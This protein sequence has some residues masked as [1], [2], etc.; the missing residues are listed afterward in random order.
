MGILNKYCLQLSLDRINFAVDQIYNL[1]LDATKKSTMDGI[2]NQIQTILG[3]LT[4]S[5]I[6][7]II[8]LFINV[9]SISDERKVKMFN[10]TIT[11]FI[12]LLIIYML[13]FYTRYKRKE[14]YVIK[15][16][17]HS[18]IFDFNY[19]IIP[20]L[21]YINSININ[22]I[23]ND[24]PINKLIKNKIIQ[25]YSYIVKNIKKILDQ[26]ISELNIPIIS[27]NIDKITIFKL[28]IIIESIEYS[29][30]NLI[31]EI[32]EMIEIREYLKNT[33]KNHIN[34]Q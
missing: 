15:K 5:G 16:S 7:L 20:K 11:M 30:N 25:D 3:S 17:K 8:G 27:E 18:V 4:V 28:K 21:I 31:N 29:I 24:N 23:K 10:F 26:H 9:F 33:I 6:I 34:L 32:P 22:D 19:I 13:I 12:I 14:Q 2:L 1:E